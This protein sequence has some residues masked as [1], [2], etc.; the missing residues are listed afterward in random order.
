MHYQS[1]LEH[2]EKDK[3]ILN[4]EVQTIKEQLRAAEN[5][6]QTETEVSKQKLENMQKEI[7]TTQEK[8]LKSIED[9]KA[10]RQVTSIYLFT[11][12]FLVYESNFLLP[13]NI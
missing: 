8:L 4:K 7:S 3:L 6:H 12:R 1:R 13:Q 5:M 11:I 2:S 10:Q 9:Q